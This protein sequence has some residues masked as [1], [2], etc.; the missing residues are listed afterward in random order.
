MAARDLAAGAVLAE[1]DVRFLRTG[2]RPE[3]SPGDLPR[4]LGR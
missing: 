2:E 1:A 3:L 4:L